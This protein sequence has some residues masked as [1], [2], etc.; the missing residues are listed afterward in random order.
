[1]I[2][3]LIYKSI[4][5][6]FIIFKAV[7]KIVTNYLFWLNNVN[8]PIKKLK[9]LR[10]FT[11]I[12]IPIIQISK[13]GE[14]TIGENFTIVNSAKAA[15]LGKNNKC[16]LL[17]YKNAELKIG[18]NVSMSNTTIVATES[19]TIGNNVMIGGG[20]TI[21]DSDF[22]S[23]NP[24]LWNTTEDE[25]KMISKLVTI[26]D[27]VFIGM[28]SI[29]LKGVS[30]GNNSIISAGSVV[31]VSIPNFQIWGGNPAKFIKNNIQYT[32]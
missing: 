23:L 10:S 12:G 6:N 2:K 16:K 32:T 5:I 31:I 8:I 22:H 29:I 24:N 15:T 27:N 28:N 4:A 25:N 17:V 21:I 9:C 18:K 1:M 20:V 7:S 11:A 26:G 30:I 14:C 19:V 3:S 13:F